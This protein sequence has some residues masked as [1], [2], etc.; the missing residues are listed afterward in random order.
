MAPVRSGGDARGGRPMS[1][2]ARPSEGNARVP[3]GETRDAE[4][5]PLA[6]PAAPPDG[7]DWS[8]TP[9]RSNALALRVMSWIA[10]RCGRRVAGWVLHPITLYF[11]VFAP[12]PR[13]HALRY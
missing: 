1:A 4:A 6:V 3:P 7:E 9:E 2:P 12:A 8:H 5:A 10:L 11:L 13:R